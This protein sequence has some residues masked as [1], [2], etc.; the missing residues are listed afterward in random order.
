MPATRPEMLTITY[1]GGASATVRFDDLPGTL[2]S[3]IL[4]QSFAAAPSPDPAAEGYVLLE[5]S[6]GWKEVVQVDA[7]CTG[8]KRYYVIRR[9]EEVG[10]LALEHESGYPVLLEVE[11]RPGG[12]RRV[13]FGE[14]FTLSPERTAREGKKTDTW[15]SLAQ[16]GDAVAELKEALAAA[17]GDTAAISVVAGRRQQDLDDFVATLGD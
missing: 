3:D 15:Y 8:I 17:G 5:W 10:R 16:S 1:P 11:R 6:D 7:G 13:T 4:R 2:Q 12:L 9:T 14:T